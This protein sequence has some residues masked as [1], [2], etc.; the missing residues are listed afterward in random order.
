MSVC[1]IVN[2]HIDYCIPDAYAFKP[3]MTTQQHSCTS[4]HLGLHDEVILP[5]ILGSIDIVDGPETVVAHD[6][7]ASVIA[8][9]VVAW[10]TFTGS[11]VGPT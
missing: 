3:H 8:Q 1:V 6:R 10:W 7:P 11:R 9:I 2:L 4:T 5:S